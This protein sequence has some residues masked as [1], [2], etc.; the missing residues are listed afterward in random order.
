MDEGSNLQEEVQ[1]IALPGPAHA[2]AQAEARLVTCIACGGLT[3][4]SHQ[5]RIRCQEC[6]TVGYVDRASRNLVPVSWDCLHCGTR[7]DG[8]TNFCLTCSHAMTAFCLRCEFPVYTSVCGRCGSHQ[9][10]LVRMHSLEQERAVWMPLRQSHL[11]S[12]QP[13]YEEAP[14]I[15]PPARIEEIPQ[16]VAKPVAGPSIAPTPPRAAVQ[17]TPQSSRRRR[18]R[19]Y[20]GSQFGWAIMWILGGLVMISR[21]FGGGTLGQI[22]TNA[23]QFPPIAALDHYSVVWLKIASA[24]MSSPQAVDTASSG[25]AIFFAVTIFGVAVLPLVT[26]VLYR[27]L[28]R[29][30]F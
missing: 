16:P 25:Y 7:N 12:Q 8:S 26:Y 20:R 3:P 14:P 9:D 29:W 19:R 15:A 28:R 23:L 5:P 30:V 11:E 18:S 24:L 6:G 4:G 27:F 1:I 17:P 10:A 21:R 13:V 2:S 22:T